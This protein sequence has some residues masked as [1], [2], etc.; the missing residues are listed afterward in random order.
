[1]EPVNKT[2]T[3]L[4]LLNCVGWWNVG[5]FLNMFELLF[6]ILSYFGQ[7]SWSYYCLI[8]CYSMI[9]WLRHISSCFYLSDGFNE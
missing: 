5:C 8:L 9:W 3:E 4:N 6:S 1:M 2:M 7:S